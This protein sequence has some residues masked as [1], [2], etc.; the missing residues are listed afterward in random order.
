LISI[1]SPLNTNGALYCQVICFN[2][3]LNYDD[4]CLGTLGITEL[5]LEVAFRLPYVIVFMSV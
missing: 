5:Q 3:R 1:F 4:G 2:N